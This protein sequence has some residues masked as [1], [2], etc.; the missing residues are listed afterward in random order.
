[1]TARALAA[2]RPKPPGRRRRRGSADGGRGLTTSSLADNYLRLCHDPCKDLKRWIAEDKARRRASGPII[3][4]WENHH[5]QTKN[6]LTSLMED[7][8]RVRSLTLHSMQGRLDT[9]RKPRGSPDDLPA[10]SRAGAVGHDQLRSLRAEGGSDLSGLQADSPAIGADFSDELGAI[11]AYYAARMAAARRALK[12]WEVAAA[13][14]TLQNERALA[15][16]A[17]MAKW[18]AARR[19]AAHRR[20]SAR[21]KPPIGSPRLSGDYRV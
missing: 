20:V 5:V 14:R 9:D 2:P 16:R 11:S 10:G 12:P 13:L 3:P 21:P 6:G 4:P 1:M 18:A 17:I 19:N 15:M 8:R 7:A